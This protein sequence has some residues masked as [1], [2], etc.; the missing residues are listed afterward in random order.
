MVSLPLA[1]PAAIV[2]FGQD[3]DAPA[4]RAQSASR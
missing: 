3:L 1:A 2:V 4:G